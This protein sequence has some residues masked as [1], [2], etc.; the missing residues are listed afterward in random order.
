MKRTRRIFTLLLLVFV[1]DGVGIGFAQPIIPREAIRS[2]TP[3]DVKQQIERL[4]SSSPLDRADAANCLGEMGERAV[5]A[6]PF[7]LGLLGDR[8]NTVVLPSDSEQR[9]VWE[10]TSPGKEAEKALAKI[11]RS[12]FWHI[13]WDF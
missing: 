13:L 12:Y 5:A 2:H 9:L 11:G 7:L 6:A 3:A 10:R 4:Y 8:A 1:M